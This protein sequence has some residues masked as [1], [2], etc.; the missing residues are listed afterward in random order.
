[1]NISA[2]LLKEMMRGKHQAVCLGYVGLLALLCP[3]K[4]LLSQR[5]GNTSFF[6]ILLSSFRDQRSCPSKLLAWPLVH[7]Q[8]PTRDC[9]LAIPPACYLPDMC[10]T[11][12]TLYLD[13]VLLTQHH[14]ARKSPKS[15][16]FTEAARTMTLK[17]F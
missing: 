1:M 15:P 2:K 9:L 10:A 6:M 8:R 16:I 7:I 4:L 13:G 17:L 11:F 14:R 5:Q 3:L 12:I